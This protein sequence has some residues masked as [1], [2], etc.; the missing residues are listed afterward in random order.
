MAG[1]GNGADSVVVDTSAAEAAWEP[2]PD[3][4][5]D[6]EDGEYPE[7]PSVA[8]AVSSFSL[9]ARIIIVVGALPFQ[10]CEHGVVS[11][12]AALQ[13]AGA[14][15]GTAHAFLLAAPATNLSTIGALVKCT[16]DVWATLR[17][18]VAISL[19][20]LALTIE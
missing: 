17:S 15:H 2:K 6:E 10:L 8:L 16:G 7:Q 11:F 12:A 20:A 9:L 18:G 4:W 5:D 1:R 19:C 13:K 14:S 3:W